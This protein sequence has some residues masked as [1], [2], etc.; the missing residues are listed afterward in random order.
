MKKILL[1]LSLSTFA[2]SC[3]NVEAN[4]QDQSKENAQST[5]TG[6]SKSCCA[7]KAKKESD[8]E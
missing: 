2:F 5:E 3:T 6:C 8:S 7:D 4:T 1:L